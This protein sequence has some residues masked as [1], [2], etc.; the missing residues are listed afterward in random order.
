MEDEM[1]D[2][3]YLGV[4]TLFFLVSVWLVTFLEDL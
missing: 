1:M 3:L 2:L 4:V